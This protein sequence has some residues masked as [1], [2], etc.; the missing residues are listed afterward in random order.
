MAKKLRITAKPAAGFHRCN[1]FH[2]STPVD[3]DP[4]RFTKAEQ[5]R[6]KDET[7]LVVQDVDVPD[8]PKKGAKGEA[9]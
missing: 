3:H 1:V 9:E 5:A 4:D 7:R 6:L 2:P 8:A